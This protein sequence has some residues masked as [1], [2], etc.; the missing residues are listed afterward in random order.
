LAEL[1]KALSADERSLVATAGLASGIR[2]GE[3]ALA[4]I[5][6]AT[7]L[8]AEYAAQAVVDGVALADARE[9]ATRNAN[10]CQ[11]L[12]QSAIE[13]ERER[14]DW[15][16]TAQAGCARCEEREPALQQFRTTVTSLTQDLERE[17][18][19][20]AALVEQAAYYKRRANAATELLELAR[21]AINEEC[22]PVWWERWR[23]FIEGQPAAPTCT[24]L[25]C[26]DDTGCMFVQP[27]APCDTCE[28]AG[29]KLCPCPTA[30]PTRTE[31]EQAVLDAWAGMPDDFLGDMTRTC[32]G[33]K[34]F[35][36]PFMKVLAAELARRG[37]K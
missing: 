8:L 6:A 36:E 34:R 32:E 20:R 1:P 22:Y 29:L 7:E 25:G 12:R 5:D 28:D 18:A 26:V 19:D 30:A 33:P 21:D 31:A 15:K 13:L 23:A 14:D 3:R 24:C 37:L 35:K 11:H 27:A 16:R 2:A 4:W 9:I 17:R 10:D